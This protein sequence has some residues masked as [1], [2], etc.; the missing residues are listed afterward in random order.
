M[1]ARA[2]W[3][4]PAWLKAPLLL[5]RFPAIFLALGAAAAI[6]GA[7][8]AA[9]PLLLSS[10]GNAALEQELDQ[11][12]DAQAG[13]SFSTFGFVSRSTFAPANEQVKTAG[14]S[15][16]RLEHPVITVKGAST[17]VANSRGQETAVR[18]LYRT[19]ALNN[20]EKLTPDRGIKGVWISDSNAAEIGVQPGDDL[21]LE[22]LR[23]R[24]VMKVAGIYRNLAS[25]PI[26]EYWKPLTFDIVNPLPNQPPLHP[27]MIM[28]SATLMEVADGVGQQATFS[29][30]FPLPLPDPTVPEA[31][32]I[33]AAFERIRLEARDPL[34]T[35]GRA[36]TGLTLFGSL[37]IHSSLPN[38]LKNT[39][40]TVTAIEGPVRLI[41]LAGRLVAL[42][43]IAAAGLFA[44][45]RRRVEA[46]LLS[47]QGRTPWWQG[48][49]AGAEAVFPA[50]LGGIV[51]WAAGIALVRMAGPSER[52]SGGVP[53]DTL[54]EVG[55]WAAGAI[56]LLAVVYGLAA[57]RDSQLGSSR[58]GHAIGR[59]P[60]EL[61]ILVL[62]VASLYEVRTRGG[63]IVEAT[64][65]AAQI[66]LF[67]LAF[68]FLFIAA[69][70]GLTTRS[71]RRSLPR[72]RAGVH[73]RSA[74]LYLSIRR[75]AGAQQIGF[76]L[77]TASAIAL[78]VLVY[79]ATLVATTSATVDA[80]A[81]VL[82]GSD[83]AAAIQNIE[84]IPADFPF[85]S[86]VVSLSTG[87]L[88][89]GDERVNII[90]VD[91]AT[92]EAG[93]FW[94]PSFA[95]RSLEDL[96]AS[97]ASDGPRLP[98]ILAGTTAPD[99]ATVEARALD[100]PVSVVDSVSAWPG[101]KPNEPSMIVDAATMSRIAQ[102]LG[103]LST[104]PFA[105]DEL[106]AKGEPETV[107]D[108]MS[109]AR[110]LVEDSRT[111]SEVREAPSLRSL[112]WTFGF[113]QAL[114]LL[115]GLIALVGLVLYLQSRQ[116]AREVS[117]ALARRMGLT[118][119]SH[120]AAVAA[121]LVA[122]LASSAVIGGAAALVAA[123]LVSGEIDPLPGLPPGSLFRIP[124]PVLV[125]APV[126]LLLVA[127]IGAWSVQRRADRMNVAE[128]M[129]LAT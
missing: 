55:T 27:Y 34:A 64:D 36:L 32:K 102:D 9:A 51:G 13:L 109:E 50:A 118:R 76:L 120:R 92:F 14:A 81:H 79:S 63:A 4:D 41:S 18:F 114:G 110:L 85:P 106:W 29:W 61:V 123:R 28:G 33:A 93:A 105:V 16:S 96:L 44:H 97:L 72:L 99:Q 40:E 125:A 56:V 88:F 74:W 107:F 19:D 65:E 84:D 71:L 12:T 94:D 122:M 54:T 101:M 115:T 86:T 116:S 80:K 98:V 69:M 83:V 57:H 15:L 39:D 42:A 35:V 46:R 67:L 58:I 124:L 48:S 3:V 47:A 6:L 129:R 68:P 53:L 127:A 108:A 10:A 59:V 95:G 21:V 22:R 104:D 25:E 77:I 112:S 60:W 2:S 100:I 70:A 20:I 52:I 117:Y 37:D 111:A 113:L 38:A 73:D 17:R 11:L 66:D 30:D 87:D 90:A 62:A 119:S 121:E 78:G 7:T 5:L 128:V 26:S 49:K 45:T 89:P 82:A 31:E 103:S 75:F 91:P 23:Q 126:V 43:V 8:T 1:R 24:R